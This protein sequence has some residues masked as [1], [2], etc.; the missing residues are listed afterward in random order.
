MSSLKLRQFL[1]EHI[2]RLPKRPLNHQ[3]TASQQQLGWQPETSPYKKPHALTFPFPGL[4]Q[5]LIYCPKL[6]EIAR[7]RFHDYLTSESCPWV[8]NPEAIKH[9]D[10]AL[11]YTD[12]TLKARKLSPETD[13]RPLFEVAYGLVLTEIFSAMSL[14][15]FNYQS[16]VAVFRDPEDDRSKGIITD[17]QFTVSDVPQMSA[18][19][20]GWKVAQHYLSR[21]VEAARSR[22]PVV[23]D[24]QTTEE[25]SIISKLAL[26]NAELQLDLAT[27]HSS[28]WFLFLK[29]ITTPIHGTFAVSDILQCDRDPIT[30]TLLSLLVKIP[31][32][33]GGKS[34]DDLVIEAIVASE[35]T[36]LDL[37]RDEHGAAVDQE[38]TL[39]RKSS[40]TLKGKE[41]HREGKDSKG[42][43]VEGMLKEEDWLG[44][45]HWHAN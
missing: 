12:R 43:P 18:E 22:K 17:C 2:K 32:E 13:V 41:K 1:S 8:I 3:P 11:Q 16:D 21:I 6:T 29:R 42:G 31:S 15:T 5:K 10:G 19:E 28:L 9:I 23:V 14:P 44:F 37:Q 30:E 39:S 7:Q 45:S 24:G 25:T 38:P 35:G 4:P 20:K 27:V 36:D 40:K 34:F 26:T 33:F